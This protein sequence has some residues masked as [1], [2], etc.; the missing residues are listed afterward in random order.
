M[1]AATISALP[2]SF[3]S[4]GRAEKK[5]IKHPESRSVPHRSAFPFYENIELTTFNR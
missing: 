1:M 3:A 4:G 5:Q 2:T